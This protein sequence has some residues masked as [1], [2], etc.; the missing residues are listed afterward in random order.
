MSKITTQLT[1]VLSWLL[2]CK[3][4]ESGEIRIQE[5]DKEDFCMPEHECNIEIDNS[6]FFSLNGTIKDLLNKSNNM[7]QRIKR[8]E[9]SVHEMM[10]T[11]AEPVQ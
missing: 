3:A 10:D 1:S 6:S 5:L 8:L 7:Y 4:I 2:M 11:Q 9:K